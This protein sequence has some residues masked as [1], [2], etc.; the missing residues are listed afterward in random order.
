MGQVF[1][2][3]PIATSPQ[4]LNQAEEFFRQNPDAGRL[5]YY[6][7]EG[8]YPSNPS[9]A[10]NGYTNN[11]VGYTDYADIDPGP[12]PQNPGY[13][14]LAAILENTLTQDWNE[15]GNP[16]NPRILQC[17]EVARQSYTCDNC[18]PEMYWCSAFVCWALEE[19]GLESKQ[20]MGSQLWYDYGAE[21]DGWRSGDYS[22]LRK[23]DI[24][25]FKAKDRDGGHIG[26][27][28]EVT[29]NGRVRI[30]GG[31][32]SNTVRISSY[33][34]ND[35]RP[36]EGLYVRSIKRNWALPESAN[37]RVDGGENVTDG[38]DSST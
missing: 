15:R 24:V 14:R 5:D 3:S 35:P 33:Y 28:H 8:D 31:N 26:F 27:L 30:L 32:Q 21:V 11:S 13:E 18:G 17:Y 29:D 7:L 2:P 4:S 37:V 16:G 38:P 25:I 34:W 9:I 12:V 36:D 20:T 1:I 6:D 23:Y 19:A 22:L 10:G